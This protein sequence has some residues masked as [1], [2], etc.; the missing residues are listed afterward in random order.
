[1]FPIPS[2]LTNIFVPVGCK[3]NEF[4]V[5]GI[6]RCL[7]GCDYFHIQIFANTENGCL[8]V[9]EYGN[10]SALIITAICK[11]CKN[12][13]LVFDDSKHGWNGFVCHDGVTPPDEILR[14]WVCPKCSC[15]IHNV[16]VG[17][18]SQGK[19]DFIDELGIDNNDSK[20]EFC[21]D[22]WINAF[23]WITV[24][25]TCFNCRCNDKKWLDHETM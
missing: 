25:L 23:D 4:H 19:D 16:E 12:N 24:G 6:I 14:P 1:M 22:D 13:Y 5:D 9:C 20:G 17:I 8:Q 11:N 21:T 10:G 7:C 2:H 15:D 18:N 3:N